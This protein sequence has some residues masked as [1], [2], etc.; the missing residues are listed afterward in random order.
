MAFRSCK[1]EDRQQLIVVMAIGGSFFTV[2]LPIV[3]HDVVSHGLELLLSLHVGVV[4]EFATTFGSQFQC[5]ESQF[6][7]R[8]HRYS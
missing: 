2:H 7:C 3:F 4:V 8:F 1:T 5:F 6:N